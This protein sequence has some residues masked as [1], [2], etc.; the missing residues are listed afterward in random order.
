MSASIS[1][2][3]A[4]PNSSFNPAKKRRKNALIEF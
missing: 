3:P 4:L 2:A 1:D